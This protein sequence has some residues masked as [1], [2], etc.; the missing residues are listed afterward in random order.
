MGHLT[1]LRVDNRELDKMQRVHNPGQPPHPLQRWLQTPA[2]NKHPEHQA[3]EPA[4]DRRLP[5]R[6]PER[7]LRHLL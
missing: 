7:H 1:I 6:E 5:Q 3:G 2:H 4:V